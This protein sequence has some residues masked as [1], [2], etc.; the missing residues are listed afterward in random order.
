MRRWLNRLNPR[1]A[2]KFATA[3]SIAWT[4]AVPMTVLERVGVRD[5]W[6][7]SRRSVKDFATLVVGSIKNSAPR[8]NWLAAQVHD[9]VGGDLRAAGRQLEPQGDHVRLGAVALYQRRLAVL[10][11]AVAFAAPEAHH[12]KESWRSETPTVPTLG[13]AIGG[14]RGGV[15]A[16]DPIEGA[17]RAI[18]RTLALRD[19]ALD[20]KGARVA[21]DNRPIGLD[22]AVVLVIGRPIAAKRQ[23]RANARTIAINPRYEPF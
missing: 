21:K 23:I 16:F 9:L 15:L 14:G 12:R 17:A 11:A 1:D 7:C 18:R 20:A 5:E 4:S 3:N 2:R 6:N 10:P 8:I 13:I 22:M 19:D